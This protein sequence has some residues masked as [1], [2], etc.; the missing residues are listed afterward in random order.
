MPGT[1]LKQAVEYRSIKK[2]TSK[3]IINKFVNSVSR[4]QRIFF[5]ESV[6]TTSSSNSRRKSTLY[7]R[8]GA[9]QEKRG[10]LLLSHSMTK[11]TKWHERPAKTQISLGIRPVWSESSL[12][13]QWA[14]KDP[15]FLH[16]DSKDW[17][18]WADA[19]AN[20]RLRWAHVS[21]LVLLCCGSYTTVRDFGTLTDTL[22]MGFGP[23]NMINAPLCPF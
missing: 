21:L 16:A 14:A 11:Q 4:L 12:C 17:S 7:N 10:A 8:L 9:E 19:Q 22:S 2:W 1:A 6:K 5:L 23:D 18:D 20:L 3:L 13:A 15:R